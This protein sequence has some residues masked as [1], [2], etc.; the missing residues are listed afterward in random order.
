MILYPLKTLENL[1]IP[2]TLVL[3]HQAQEVWDVVEK[4]QIKNVNYV[5]QEQQL[6]T[7]HA[8]ATTRQHW[9]QDNI[10]IMYGDMPLV[11]RELFEQL[12]KEHQKEQ[13]TI[14][15]LTTMV[16]DPHGY[17][18]IIEEDNK[19]Y[20][21]EEK[22]CTHEQRQVNKIN[23]GIYLIKKDFLQ[24]SI[25][26]LSKN[27]LTGE[28]Y[29]PDLVEIACKKNLK[30]HPIP[31]AFDNVRGVN[32]L[33]ELWAVEQ[34][35]RSESIKNW[36]ANG[37]QFELAQSIHIDI[38]VTIGAGSFI[39]TGTHLLGNT[40]IGEESFISAFSIVENTTIGDGTVVHSHSVIQNSKI[41]SNVHVGPFARVRKNVVIG[42]F[43]NVGNFVEIKNTQIGE[44]SKTKH[45]SY[46]GDATI[47]NNVNIGAGT[48]ICNYDGHTKSKTEIA[49]NVFIGSN[50][51]LIAP[52][53][54]GEGSYT[55]GGSTIN[56]DVP[57]NTLAIG[58]SKQENKVGYADKLHK[59]PGNT[60]GRSECTSE[61]L[62][63]D[64]DDEPGFNFHGAIKTGVKHKE[65]L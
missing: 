15:L 16:L 3:G 29:L 42:D 10:L 59:D 32:N 55:A 18:R 14:S 56:E 21:V 63:D 23:A 65:I 44:H 2:V 28:I 19:I 34:I 47:G 9:D 6:G 38:D 48:I 5:I 57:D 40:V 1:N 13:A 64:F 43:S 25:D 62:H 8:V 60:N 26:K 17:G 46:I 54:I 33:Q 53:K 30:V 61:S 4:S 50:N 52:I 45:L 51:T 31:V 22:N 27:D 20:I 41:G 11:T 39:G 49:N 36:M 7:G 12:L 37:V 24:E 35:K 58:R